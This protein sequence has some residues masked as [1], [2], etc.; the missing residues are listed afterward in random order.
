MARDGSFKKKRAYKINGIFSKY[1]FF[2]VLQGTN[3]DQIFLGRKFGPGTQV[4]SG[5]VA[6]LPTCNNFS[7]KT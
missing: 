4:G 7:E 6:D 1:I 5:K 3:R 2:L